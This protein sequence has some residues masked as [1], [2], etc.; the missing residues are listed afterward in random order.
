MKKEPLGSF[1]FIIA[2]SYNVIR[3]GGHFLNNKV[4]I[5][6]TISVIMIIISITIPEKLGGYLFLFR[7][8]P[9]IMLIY[10]GYIL[11]KQT[12]KKPN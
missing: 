1:S 12:K 4:L 10:I 7:L 9:G 6:L 3:F 5:L 11:S 2:F 8:I